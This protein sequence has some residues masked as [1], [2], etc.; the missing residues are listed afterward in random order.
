[1]AAPVRT[2][3]RPKPGEIKLPAQTSRRQMDLHVPEAKMTVRRMVYGQEA[4]REEQIE[5][6]A[7]HGPVAHVRVSGSV[8]KNLGDYNS[9]RVEVSVSLPC[10]PTDT[11][12]AAT[13]RRGSE[14]VDR[15]VSRELDIATGVKD[16][17]DD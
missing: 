16:P 8:T 13:Y 3:Q 6:P 15:F 1:M 2:R 4:E 11:E 12:I 5:V 10:Y 7:F 14:M 17:E 9:A